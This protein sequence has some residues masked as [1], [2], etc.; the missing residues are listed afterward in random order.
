MTTTKSLSAQLE[1]SRQATLRLQAQADAIDAAEH[2]ARRST[3][4]ALIEEARGAVSEQYRDER[5]ELENRVN[6]LATAETLD[7]SAL[8]DAFVR[9]HDCD[10][11]CYAL[12]IHGARINGL[13]PVRH[14][15]IGVEIPYPP[16][17]GD[18]FKDTTW[19]AFLDRTITTRRNTIS[20]RHLA[21]LQAD[22][23]STIDAA[24]ESARSEAAI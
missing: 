17:I 3:E 12:G 16:S 6:A 2:E 7:I 5:T 10:A 13:L 4:L 23:T 18:K 22:L 21:E 15:T 14:N 24:A 1:E 8:L 20:G 19:S 11:R 9:L